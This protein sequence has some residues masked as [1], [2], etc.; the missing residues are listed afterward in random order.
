MEVLCFIN[1]CISILSVVFFLQTQWILATPFYERRRSADCSTESWFALLLT[2]LYCLTLKHKRSFVPGLYGTTF[3]EFGTCIIITTVEMYS[4]VII[5]KY[6]SLFF[7]QMHQGSLQK[8]NVNDHWETYK[9]FSHKIKWV[10]CVPN[11][12]PPPTTLWC[13]ETSWLCAFWLNDL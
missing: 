1:T 9:Y 12:Y 6:L 13:W 10:N 5:V 8:C 4:D 3:R 7:N 2:S 11:N